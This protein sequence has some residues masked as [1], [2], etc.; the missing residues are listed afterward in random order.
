MQVFDLH[1][2]AKY[3]NFF[4][5]KVSLCLQFDVVLVKITQRPLREILPRMN[6]K[7]T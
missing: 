1:E 3:L 6:S 2:L 7:I 4:R 5:S